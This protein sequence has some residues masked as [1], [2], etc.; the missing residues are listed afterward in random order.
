[1]LY[2]ARAGQGRSESGDHTVTT[3]DGKTIHVKT[4]GRVYTADVADGDYK[5]TNG[6]A[7]RVNGGRVVWDAF[8]SVRRLKTN[9]RKLRQGPDPIG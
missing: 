2:G 9:G 8:G 1:M 4:Q 7:I 6:G 5:L 3:T